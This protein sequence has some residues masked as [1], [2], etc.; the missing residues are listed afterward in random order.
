MRDCIKAMLYAYPL[1]DTVSEDYRQHIQ[2][3]AILSYLRVEPAG[4]IAER[5]AFEILE[6][7]VLERFKTQVETILGGLTDAERALVDIRYFKRGEK[8]KQALLRVLG[9]DTLGERRY[10]RMQSRLLDK[11]TRCFERIG[12][13]KEYF[14]E[15]LA[16]IDV[17][18]KTLRY[19]KNGKAERATESERKW[20]GHESIGYAVK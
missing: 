3:K 1:L 20:L 4:N 2:N 10:F 6:K 17:F 16:D 5:I 7:R 11:L 14:E 9:E 8:A 15:E 12:L 19:T 18:K 13:T